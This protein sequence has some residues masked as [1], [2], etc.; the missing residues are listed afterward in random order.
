MT[1]TPFSASRWATAAPITPAPITATGSRV[2]R[3]QQ[4]PAGESGIDLM[5]V[6]DAGT[7][8]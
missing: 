4:S 7:L 3:L 8:A 1:A 5:P 2:I 6:A